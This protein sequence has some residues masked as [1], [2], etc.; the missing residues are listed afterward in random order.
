M[1]NFMLRVVVTHKKKTLFERMLNPEQA[2]ECNA[3]EVITGLRQIFPHEA[4]ITLEAYG[5]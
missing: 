4:A 1:V 3:Q 2:R 5:V